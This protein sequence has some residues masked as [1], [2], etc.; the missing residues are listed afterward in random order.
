MTN[1]VAQLRKG[2]DTK[3]VPKIDFK[4]KSMHMNKRMKFGE[5][6]SDQVCPI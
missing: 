2:N 1:T 6:D 5:D 3:S 4:A